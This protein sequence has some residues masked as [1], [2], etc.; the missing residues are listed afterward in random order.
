MRR[1]A[2]TDGNQAD[3]VDDLRELG[4]SVQILASVG[5]GCP[6]LLVGAYGQNH[7]FEVKDPTKPKRDQMLT[8]DQAKWHGAWNGRVV[9]IKSFEDAMMEIGVEDEARAT[10]TG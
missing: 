9:V 8:K 2:R 4:F 7:L 5:E 6:D 1:A 10:E 3:I